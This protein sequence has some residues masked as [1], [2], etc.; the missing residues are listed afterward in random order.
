ML[1]SGCLCA[2]FHDA[3][4]VRSKITVS[5]KK[6]IV[7]PVDEARFKCNARRHM[8]ILLSAIWPGLRG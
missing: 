2:S 6:H 1:V 8:Q 3:V 4:Q 7:H 5:R